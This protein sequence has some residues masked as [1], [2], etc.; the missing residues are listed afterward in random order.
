MSNNMDFNQPYAGRLTELHLHLDGSLRPAS[1]VELAKQ[2]NIQLP[3]ED[4]RS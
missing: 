2:Q 1:V 4:L 3:T